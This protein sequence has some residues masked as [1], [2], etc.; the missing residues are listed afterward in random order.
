MKTL[1][2][3]FTISALI[4]NKGYVYNENFYKIPQLPQLR[5]VYSFFYYFIRACAGPAR[6]LIR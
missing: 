3:I 1:K 2:S 6:L 4:K 5:G